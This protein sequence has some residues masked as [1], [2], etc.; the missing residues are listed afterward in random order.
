MKKVEL[1]KQ[2][3]FWGERMGYLEPARKPRTKR[4]KAELEQWWR[5]YARSFLKKAK[6]HFD[7]GHVNAMWDTVIFCERTGEP[8]PAWVIPAIAEFAQAAVNGHAAF[9]KEG[10]RSNPQLDLLIFEEVEELVNTHGV[11]KNK[12][13]EEVREKLGLKYTIQRDSMRPAY[14]R[15]KKIFSDP[16]SRYVSPFLEIPPE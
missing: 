10:R 14:E 5:G 4:E 1:T 9:W 2:G 11:S 8:W 7:I 13:Y 15:G 16:D 3:E 6:R 12:A